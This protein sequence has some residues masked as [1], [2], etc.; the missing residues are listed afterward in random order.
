MPEAITATPAAVTNGAAPL[1][2][3]VSGNKFTDGEP[4]TWEE[5]R[6]A[7]TGEEGTPAPGKAKEA[8]P[9][10][11][12]PEQRAER[13]RVKD[14]KAYHAQRKG[15]ALK[16][17]DFARKQADGQRSVEALEK[18]TV[19]LDARAK[20]LDAL[21]TDPKAFVEHFAKRMGMT[22]TKVVNALNEFFL[23][24][25]DPTELKLNKLEADLKRRDEEA[26]DRTKKEAAERATA[27]ATARVNG[28]KAK[29]AE[30]VASRAEEFT[31]LPTYEPEQVA[32]AAWARID[33]HYERTKQNI[34]LDKV[35][36]DLES[37]EEKLYL[38]KEEARKRRLGGAQQIPQTPARGGATPVALD[39]AQRPSTL[40]NRLATQRST[41][42]RQ[43]SD[44][45][46]WEEAKRE[47]GAER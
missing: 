41:Q 25:K 27:E 12:T 3:E 1:A 38:K 4:P 19:E 36:A 7:A 39:E 2:A 44:S 28:Y 40:T 14:W 16:E 46:A 37:D 21:E 32:E 43:L 29:I 15:L 11:E 10:T 35:L 5:A 22:P 45:E 24:N 30:I 20:T 9:K 23:E 33:A 42:S 17:A 26:A 47:V 18:R 13:I 31:F 6:D 8:K 34:P